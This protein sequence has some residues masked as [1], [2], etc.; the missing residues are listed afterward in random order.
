MGQYVS[1]SNEFL[2]AE[3]EQLRTAIQKILQKATV[4][5]T[6]AGT[7]WKWHG[8]PPLRQT[9]IQKICEQALKG[10]K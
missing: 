5:K 3:I 7:Q 9:Q 1:R 8:I 10:D 2:E 4:D 6:W